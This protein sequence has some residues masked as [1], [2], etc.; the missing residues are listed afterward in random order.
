[1]FFV[2]LSNY[3]SC[4]SVVGDGGSGG[5]GGWGKWG[6]AQLMKY[7]LQKHEDSSSYSEHPH[8]LGQLN[9]CL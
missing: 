6:M 5:M 3:Q 9:V 4:V 1:M 8:K 2:S 7:L